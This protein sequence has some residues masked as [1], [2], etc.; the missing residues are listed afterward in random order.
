MAFPIQRR[1]DVWSYQNPDKVHSSSKSMFLWA[2]SALGK[3]CCAAAPHCQFKDRSVVCCLG[4]LNTAADRAM[5]V[6]CCPSNRWRKRGPCQFCKRKRKQ[7]PP[8]PFHHV[9]VRGLASLAAI[10][11]GIVQPVCPLLSVETQK[12]PWAQPKQLL[13]PSFAASR[14]PMCYIQMTFLTT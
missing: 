10:M 12:H 13:C 11:N 2:R 8:P 1:M 5:P 9:G 6:P 7:P 3:G 14:L 4:S